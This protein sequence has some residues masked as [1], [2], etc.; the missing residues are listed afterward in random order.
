MCFMFERPVE[1]QLRVTAVKLRVLVLSVTSHLSP[2]PNS[3]LALP[4]VTTDT[5]CSIHTHTL[6]PQYFAV[7][8]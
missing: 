7:Y 4:P 8:M 6:N 2:E 1:E 3:A 5:C